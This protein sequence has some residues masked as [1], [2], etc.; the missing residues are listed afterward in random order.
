MTIAG[1]GGLHVTGKVSIG[2]NVPPG[3]SLDVSGNARVSGSFISGNTTTYGDGTI[4][5]STGTNLNI[6]SNTLFVD[7]ANNRV[8]IGTVS[9]SQALH[10][11]TENA[12]ETKIRIAGAGANAG[13]E[14]GELL[15]AIAADYETNAGDFWRIDANQDNLRFG[16]QSFTRVT[17]TAVGDVGIGTETPGEPRM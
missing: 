10:V 16:P 13:A 6:D 17:F 2:L 7:N 15:L 4:T 8:G 3:E 11:G 9:P 1:L 5:L 12:G 14:G